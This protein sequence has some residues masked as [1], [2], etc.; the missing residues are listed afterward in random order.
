MRTAWRLHMNF[1]LNQLKALFGISALATFY[2]ISSTIIWALGA[3]LDVPVLFRI[4]TI[5]SI[6][7]IIPLKMFITRYRQKRSKTNNLPQEVT[8]NS[9]AT[10]NQE[11]G[12][13]V[14]EPAPVAPKTSTLPT[15]DAR[16]SEAIKFLQSTKMGS[17][18]LYKLPWYLVIGPP[19]S[20]KTSLLI[21]SKFDFQPLS[22][23]SIS[24][25]NLVQPTDEFEWRITSDAVF[26]DTPGYYQLETNQKQKW[27]PALES[28]KKIRKQ[29]PLD[30]L[31]I[32][33]NLA[34]ILAGPTSE[35]DQLAKSIR[36]NIDETMARISPLIPIYIVFTNSAAIRGFAEF[37]SVLPTEQQSQVWGT[38]IPLERSLQ[39]HN[40]IDAEFETLF[41]SLLTYRLPRLA[42]Y[43]ID[44]K[45]SDEKCKILGFPQRF[46]EARKKLTLFLVATLR[47]NSFTQTPLFRGFYF[48]NTTAISQPD[49]PD[50]LFLD[51]SFFT[52]DLFSQ[53]ILKDK[54]I[55]SFLQNRSRYPNLV[56]NSLAIGVASLTF[57][58]TIGLIISF[59]ANRSLIN[60]VRETAQVVRDENAKSDQ[61]PL[62]KNEI[63]ARTEIEN[64]ERLRQNLQE[65]QTFSD[66]NPPL[67][68]RFG[69][70][71]GGKVEPYARS[72]Y[73]NS[74]AQRYFRHSTKAIEDELTNFASN[75]QD[76]ENNLEQH[77]DLLKAYL[78]LSD[79]KPA[80]L[81]IDP[82]IITDTFAPYWIAAAPPEVQPIS[83]RQLEFYA[84]QSSQRD[85]VPRLSIIGNRVALVEN[86]RKVLVKYPPAERILKLLLDKCNQAYPNEAVTLGKLL[87]RPTNAITG[88]P[89]ARPAFTL[90]GYY[91][92]MK[93]ALQNAADDIKRED[94][95]MGPQAM[96]GTNDQFNTKNLEERY[97]SEYGKEWQRFLK[98]IDLPEYQNRQEASAVLDELASNDS[99]LL[100]ILSETSRQAKLSAGLPNASYLSRIKQ[101]FTTKQ[102]VDSTSIEKEYTPLIDLFQPKDDKTPVLADYRTDLQNLSDALTKSQSNPEQLGVDLLANKDSL[103][104]LEAQK[105][106]AKR[107]AN[108]A[109]SSREAAILLEKP[110][111]NLR[112]Y[113]TGT[114]DKD[115]QQA[116]SQCQIK[117]QEL[118]NL[119]PFA[120]SNTDVSIADLNAYLNPVDGTFTQ[121]FKEKLAA[122]LTD[123]G[124]SWRPKPNNPFKFSQQFL[125]YINNLRT[126]RESLYRGNAPQMRVDYQVSLQNM[127]RNL[128][129]EI[130]GFCVQI[131]A[132]SSISTTPSVPGNGGQPSFT[133]SNSCKPSATFSWPAGQ[134]VSGLGATITYLNAQGQPQG[135]PNLVPGAWGLLKLIRSNYSKNLDDSIY[136]L[137]F[138][139]TIQTS[140]KNPFQPDLKLFRQLKAPQNMID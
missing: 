140:K 59:F 24:D 107:T 11:P 121:F 128:R 88:N 77:Y 48:A 126:L 100:I 85:D 137:S 39:A 37:F 117:A 34:Q 82:V 101:Y 71:C 30:G 40:T 105:R 47:P 32:S 36:A 136:Q 74:I 127:G 64:L 68:L 75:T 53:V 23:H 70:Y 80:D 9:A 55:A 10:T 13:T 116:W 65:L 46:N 25:Q 90:Q 67:Y 27:I 113:L 79:Q 16:A 28:L 72:I 45:Q 115:V 3:F 131:S 106:H 83:R 111:T 1:N 8:N 130:D 61:D 84:Q 98:Q 78:M 94:W 91:G 96:A 44:E 95:I 62:N 139:A 135:Q 92:F 76:Q 7:L 29:R 52:K 35:I 38:T 103:G 41:Q 87:R 118:E 22:G 109:G 124:I 81:P 132:N 89:I 19:Q 119:F 50:E 31:I 110:L 26:I 86:C 33:I 4:I 43:G 104:L 21:S 51:S 63:L 134:G 17:A 69:L 138:G 2:G 18:A 5:L 57:L 14:S 114:T 122:Y 112:K 120:D 129:L 15:I 73:F 108:F 58:L 6:I 123:D 56:R 42:V 60:R 133:G 93:A 66:E 102:L 54:D 125:T 12:S 49:Q 99:P 97:F 20:G